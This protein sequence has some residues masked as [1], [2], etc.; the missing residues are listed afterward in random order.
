MLPLPA[1][2]Q[3]PE[4]RPPCTSLTPLL[5]VLNRLRFLA[6]TCRATA[7]LDLQEACALIHADRCRERDALAAALIRVL[8]Q[9]MDRRVV[10][11]SPGAPEMTFDEQWL[12]RVLAC[13]ANRDTPSV[14]FLL[15]SR[16]APRHHH[17]FR[18]IVRAVG[19]L[20]RS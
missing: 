10:F 17:A 20:L 15:R 5:P 18:S 3:A 16:V 12:L 6:Q 13:A 11:L 7:R 19:A 9:V 1:Q 2:T 4:A 14:E 8:S